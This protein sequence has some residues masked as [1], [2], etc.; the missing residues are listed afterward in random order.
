MKKIIYISF[1]LPFLSQAQNNPDNGNRVGI[2]SQQ[3]SV[4]I[5]KGNNSQKMIQNENQSNAQFAANTNDTSQKKQKDPY[6]KECEEIKKLKREQKTEQFSSGISGVKRKKHYFIR[7]YIR[8]SQKVNRVFGKH[9]KKK[10][11]YN[12]SCFVW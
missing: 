12:Y 3:N 11:D 9:K 7:F 6:C 10:L 2:V 5:I 8:T 4:D 1:L